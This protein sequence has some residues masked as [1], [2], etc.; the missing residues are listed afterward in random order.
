MS[1]CDDC[2]H[3]FKPK[4]TRMIIQKVRDAIC[5]CTSQTVWVIHNGRR[6]PLHSFGRVNYSWSGWC[7]RNG[8]ALTRSDMCIA[9]KKRDNWEPLHNRSF[10]IHIEE[11]DKW[12]NVFRIEEIVAFPAMGEDSE[13]EDIEGEVLIHVHDEDDVLR[14]YEESQP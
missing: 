1:K 10:T 3:C 7:Y 9:L 14:A 5:K 12:V 13:L 4:M 2:T 6:F 11:T 8:K